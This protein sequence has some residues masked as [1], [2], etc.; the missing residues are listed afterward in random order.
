MNDA[1]PRNPVHFTYAP[2]DESEPPLRQGDILRP[3]SALRALFADVHPHFADTKY[4]A[5]FVL[6]QT[7]DLVR[8]DRKNCKSRYINV[9]VVRPLRDVLLALLDREC[10]RAKLGE[11]LLDGIYTN[12]SRCRGVQLLQRIVNQNAQAEGLFYL[13]K[14]AAVEI[15]FPSVALLQVSVAVRAW[16]HYDTLVAARCGRLKPEFQSK[17]G[18]LIGNLFSRVATED[19]KPQDRDKIIAEFLGSRDEDDEHRPI[20]IPRKHIQKAD[21]GNAKVDGL[22]RAQ[23]GALLAQQRPEPPKETALSKVVQTLR[24]LLPEIGEERVNLV[25]KQLAKDP[26]FEA[27]CKKE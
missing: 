18:W 15:L 5:F 4:T 13:H 25:R 11:K 3:A 7:C 24:E 17:L 19:M 22:S 20:W 27:A 6:T 9:A 14:D 2:I 10:E 26:V 1:E 8:R 21:K 16:E 12:E 23:I